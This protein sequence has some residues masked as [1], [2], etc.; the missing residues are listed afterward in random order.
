MDKLENNEH[1]TNIEIPETNSELQISHS[2]NSVEKI[3]ENHSDQDNSNYDKFANDEPELNKN[4]SIL[5]KKYSESVIMESH[6][7]STIK[8]FEEVTFKNKRKRLTIIDSDSETEEQL[9]KSVGIEYNQ[10]ESHTT[11]L[12]TKLDIEKPRKRLAVI[13]SDSENEEHLEKLDVEQN[14]SENDTT[15]C[16]GNLIL[17]APNKISPKKVCCIV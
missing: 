3:N 12:K 10:A 2:S 7:D 5:D 1:D 11:D 6:I 8:Q 9:E 16:E 15:E 17:E 13:N 4:K 14:E